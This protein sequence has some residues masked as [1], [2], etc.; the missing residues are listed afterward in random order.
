ML[1]AYKSN[2]NVILLLSNLSICLFIFDKYKHVFVNYCFTCLYF[3]E[4]EIHECPDYLSAG[5]DSCYFNE[6]ITRLWQTY[7]ISVKATNDAG[8]N[9]SDPHYVNLKEMVKPNPPM[10][11]SLEVKM[12]NGI[13][14]MWTKWSPSRW[15][16]DSVLCNYELR[17]KSAEGKKWENYFV[18]QQLQYKISQLHPGMKYTAQVRCVTD[19]GERSMWSSERYIYFH[20]GFQECV[21]LIKRQKRHAVFFKGF[22][23][24]FQKE[25]FHSFLKLQ[26]IQH[27]IVIVNMQI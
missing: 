15:V 10:N 16:N 24:R 27:S 21:Y 19:R 18:G 11:L 25:L 20:R 26:K 6:R 3:S 5:P 7:N 2:V 14:Y 22:Q 1:H 23:K 13:M 17:L 12:I 4:E 9:L 8:S